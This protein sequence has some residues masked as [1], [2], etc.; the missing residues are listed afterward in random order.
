[1]KIYRLV[2][3]QTLPIG[4][5]EAWAFFSSPRNLSKITSV[6]MQLKLLSISGRE[7]IYPGQLIQYRMKIFPL[8]STYWLT[9]I[10]Q[11]QE[12]FYF[13]DE[14][15]SGP[16]AFWQH[17]HHF[18]EVKDGTEVIDEVHYAVPLGI[19]GRVVNSLFVDRQVNA[20]FDY[21]SRILNEYFSNM[22]TTSEI[23]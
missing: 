18:R 11:V 3:N 1:M 17:Q 16:Y 13:T 10:T 6:K 14:Q 23:A 4:L 19:A 2:R 20:I 7:K 21:R 9:E 8:I 22:S 5:K 12:P 15:R